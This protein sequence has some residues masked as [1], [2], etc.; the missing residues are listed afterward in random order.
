MFSDLM[1]DRILIK[2]IDGKTYTDVA[3]SVQ[4]NKIFTER[5]DIP[6]R[7][8]D[9][10]VRKTPAG[11]E[12]R[13]IVEDPGFHAGLDD[14]PATYQMQVR[15]A[16]EGAAGTTAV[17][18]ETAY[19]KAFRLL[20]FLYERTC[21]KTEPVPI[22]E[23]MKGGIGLSEDEVKAAWHYLKDKKLVDTFR[24]P[25]TARINARGIDV[26]EGAR[27][28]P[29]EPAQFFPSVT[30][31][32]VTVQNMVGSTIR[33][34]GQCRYDERGDLRMVT[35]QDKDDLLEVM[36]EMGARE[37]SVVFLSQART[38]LDWEEDRFWDTAKVLED[39]KQI[40][41]RRAG[42]AVITFKARRQVEARLYPSPSYTQNTMTVHTMVNSPVQQGGA[43]ANM[44]QNVG[45]SHQDTDELRRLVDLFENHI[46]DLSLDVA[47]KRKARAQVAT[48]KA[49]LEDEPDHVI[50]KQAGRTLRNL[51]EGAIASLLATAAQPA[52]W[53]WAH[54]IMPKLFGGP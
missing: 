20:Q 35:E 33:Q 49:Q 18:Q 22:T 14:I 40:E 48:I 38:H 46:D 39:E 12:E 13:Y 29:N 10:I 42:H 6:I 4:R 37:N 34:T 7:P 47:D 8:G 9:S 25:Y 16:P 44:T 28:R 41:L 3:A 15:S 32:Y 51:T 31:N 24:V 11:V 5:T 23:G 53:S 43:Y 2:T 21:G 27:S 17:V 1:N 30:Y 50:V 26:I 19:I 52:V 45:Y 36:Y 54:S